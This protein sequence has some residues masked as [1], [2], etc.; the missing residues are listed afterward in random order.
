M[1]RTYYGTCD[2]VNTSREREVRSLGKETDRG[3]R[4]GFAKQ[5]SVKAKT[6]ASIGLGERR[7]VPEKEKRELSLDGLRVT[8]GPGWR[9]GARASYVPLRKRPPRSRPRRRRIAAPRR[10]TRRRR[11][12]TRPAVARSRGSPP[13]PRF[14]APKT[15]PDRDARRPR[16]RSGRARMRARR[17]RRRVRSHRRR[18]GG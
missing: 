12:R 15:Q 6:E 11:R 9:L 10:A 8:N 1:K 17:T 5:K 7:R 13:P 16:A 14:G 3:R 2:E 18:R 4:G